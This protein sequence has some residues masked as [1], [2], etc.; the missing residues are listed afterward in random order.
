MFLKITAASVLMIMSFSDSVYNYSVPAIEGGTQSLSVYSQKKIMLVTLP[1][2]Q[3]AAADSMLYSLDTLALAHQDSLA[4]IAVPSIE[5]GYTANQQ[6]ALQQ[7]YRGK[8]GSHIIITAGLYS[9]RTSG[10]QQHV[11]FRW[12]TDMQQNGR[13]DMDVSGPGSIFFIRP[14]GKLYAVVSPEVRIWSNVL[15]RIIAATEVAD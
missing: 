7:W 2:V 6:A 12:L 15:N 9:R 1:L 5:D 14:G 3:N 8:L 10:G 4:V 13:F 11:L